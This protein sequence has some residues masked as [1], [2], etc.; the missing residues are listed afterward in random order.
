MRNTGKMIQRLE[1]DLKFK[2]IEKLQAGELYDLTYILRK[3]LQLLKWNMR[4]QDQQ[5]EGDG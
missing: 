3:L 5:K 2:A 4:E 1:K